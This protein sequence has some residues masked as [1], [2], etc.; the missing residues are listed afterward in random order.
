[1]QA[2][3]YVM[4]LL[5]VVGCSGSGADL[6]S[7]DPFA[8]MDTLGVPVGRPQPPLVSTSRGKAGNRGWT[9]PAT[10]SSSSFAGHWRIAADLTAH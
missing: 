6:Q 2:S 1:M 9:S 5:W 4:A 8:P 10:R 3:I 7:L